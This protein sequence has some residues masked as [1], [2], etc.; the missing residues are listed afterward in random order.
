MHQHTDSARSVSSQRILRTPKYAAERLD[1]SEARLAKWRS[2]GVGPA[3]LKIGGRVFY[4]DSAIDA[5]ID[6]CVVHPG[7]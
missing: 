6:S 3:Y 2:S 5:F 4:E 7:S 1:S